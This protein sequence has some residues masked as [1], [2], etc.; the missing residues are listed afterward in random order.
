MP[1]GIHPLERTVVA[2]DPAFLHRRVGEDS[3]KYGL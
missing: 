1:E 3:V 2:M